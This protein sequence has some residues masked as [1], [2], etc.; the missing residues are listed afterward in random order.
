MARGNFWRML[1]IMMLLYVLL[2]VAAGAWFARATTTDWDDTLYVGVY[3]IDGDDSPV[4]ARYIEA[5]DERT[6]GDVERFIEREA[7]RFGIAIDSPLRIEVGEPVADH[8]PAPPASRNVLRV[9][10]WSLSLRYWAWR[11][12][13]R[14]PGPRPNVSIYVVYHDPETSPVLAHS[15]GLEKGLIGVVNAFAS[16]RLAGANNVVIAHELLHTLGATDKYDPLTNLPLFPVGYAEPDLRPL[17]PQRRAEIMGGRTPL[18][19]TDAVTPASLDEV[20]VG[21]VTAVEIRW[22]R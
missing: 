6:F 21:P 18:S 15:L 12:Q 7:A 8:P 5:L 13:G 19:P 11:M 2:F 4:S 1:R 17:H 3:P 10:A 22:K 16:R 20:I 9:M 14:Q